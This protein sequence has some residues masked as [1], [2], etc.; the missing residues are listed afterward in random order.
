MDR[1]S[2]ILDQIVAIVAVLLLMALGLSF[3]YIVGSHIGFRHALEEVTADEIYI[4]SHEPA[5]GDV[6]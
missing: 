1:R 4:L 3:G 6:R 2:R 5:S